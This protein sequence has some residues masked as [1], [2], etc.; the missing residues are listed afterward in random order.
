[1]KLGKLVLL[2]VL[3]GMML[4]SCQ[5]NPTPNP[6]NI[7]TWELYPFYGELRFLIACFAGTFFIYL[8]GWCI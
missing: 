5:A 8:Q 2:T 3:F 7:E 1:M 6:D 4:G